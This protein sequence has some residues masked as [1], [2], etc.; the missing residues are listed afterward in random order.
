MYFAT[1]ADELLGAPCQRL[2]AKPFQLG[3]IPVALATWSLNLAQVHFL[4]T[5]F[6]RCI[7]IFSFLRRCR[8]RVRLTPHLLAAFGS[9][10][11]R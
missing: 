10:R 2:L 8:E 11:D 1:A 3:Y 6:V 9:Q 4:Q 7:R 5:E